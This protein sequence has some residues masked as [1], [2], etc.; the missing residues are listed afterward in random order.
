MRADA[1][2]RGNPLGGTYGAGLSG[3]DRSGVRCHHGIGGDQDHSFDC[4]LEN[5]GQDRLISLF[6]DS[7]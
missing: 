2:A 4:G 5:R 1:I 3:V 7:P 6:D